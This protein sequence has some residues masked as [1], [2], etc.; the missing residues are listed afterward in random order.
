MVALLL[1]DPAACT[2]RSARRGETDEVR[3]SAALGSYEEFFD[4]GALRCGP[5]KD[6]RANGGL[7]LVEEWWVSELSGS[8]GPRLP[9]KREVKKP[10]VALLRRL[11]GGGVGDT[12]GGAVDGEA[13]RECDGSGTA[14]KVC[15]VGERRRRGVGDED[16]EA[17]RCRRTVSSLGE[18]IVMIQGG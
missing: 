9:L 18:R 15:L 11:R 3:S 10:V 7:E 12:D 6:F 1:G 2:C 16:L 4:W 5:S 8:T 14:R 13:V 17:R